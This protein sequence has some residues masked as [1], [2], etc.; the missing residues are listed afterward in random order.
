MLKDFLKTERS[1][2]DLK[3]ALSVIRE[4]KKCESQEE[5]L[6]IFFST[7]ERLEELEEFLETLTK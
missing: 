3:T 7:W 1:V 2:E 5:Y 6:S 4:Y